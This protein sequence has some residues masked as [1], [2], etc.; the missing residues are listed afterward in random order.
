[1]F[2]KGVILG[3]D[4]RATNGNISCDNN[5]QKIHYLAPNIC[6][7]GAG[8]SADAENITNFGKKLC[9]CISKC[10]KRNIVY[11]KRI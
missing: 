5:C 11:K 6:C 4:T 2:D 10:S 8:T 3:A 9:D 1:M 7:M